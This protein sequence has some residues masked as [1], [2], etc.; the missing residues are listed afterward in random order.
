MYSKATKPPAAKHTIFSLL[1]CVYKTFPNHL[2]FWF[3]KFNRWKL[4]AYFGFYRKFV[5]VFLR[6]KISFY[7][8]LKIIFH[9]QKYFLFSSARCALCSGRRKGRRRKK[10]TNEEQK[11]TT[12]TVFSIL[13]ALF[14][15]FGLNT[16]AIHVL[17]N[18]FIRQVITCAIMHLCW[19]IPLIVVDA[20]DSAF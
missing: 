14:R 17:Y 12:E 2:H 4:E 10:R 16:H 7:F 19:T 13:F 8:S 20:E 5:Y 9:Q 6:E 1:M 3:N 15:F 18:V 11:A